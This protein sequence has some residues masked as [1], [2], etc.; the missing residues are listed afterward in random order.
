VRRPHTE[1]HQQSLN[2]RLNQ[3]NLIIS[4]AIDAL[5]QLEK[6]TDEPL[7]DRLTPSAVPTLPE[8][9]YADVIT[10]G[11]KTNDS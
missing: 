7:P 8:S 10:V 9:A 4:V 6:I 3:K 11:M 5:I 2:R 1:S